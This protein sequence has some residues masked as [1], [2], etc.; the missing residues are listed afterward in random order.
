MTG[1]PNRIAFNERLSIDIAQ[2]HERP[3]KLALFSI[4]LDG[5][6]D[7]NDL[8]GHSAGDHLLIEVAE[9]M[10]GALRPGEFLARQGGDEFLALQSSRNLPQDAQKF[11]ERIAQIFAEPFVVQG[12]PVM[13]SASIGLSIFPTDTRERDQLLSNAKLAMHSGKSRQR[14]SIS[15]YQRDIDDAARAR[16]ALA[17]DLECAAE[18]GEL[19]LRYQLQLSL[20]DGTICGSEARCDGTIPG[21]AWSPRPNSSLW[22]KTPRPSSASA[23]GCCARP[24]AMPPQADCRAPSRS[25]CRRFSSAAN[26]AEITHTILL[27]TGLAPRRLEVT[28]S[29][30]TAD[31]ARE[32]HTLRKLKTLAWRKP[33]H[34]GARRRHRDESAVAISGPGRLRQ[35]SGLSIR[36]TGAGCQIAR[37]DRSR[38]TIRARR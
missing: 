34:A 24:A 28:E 4:D 11:A 26:L 13:L 25:T 12:Q 5:F 17:R 36:Q 14:G 1:L 16:R 19:E 15:M 22:R 10:R 8:F 3:D 9:R 33:R 29:T 27:E 23:N 21:A 7:V 37:G 18:R 31:Q 20:K 6:E 32:L 35:G 38:G 2:A 30:L